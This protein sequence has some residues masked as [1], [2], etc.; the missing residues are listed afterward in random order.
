MYRRLHL[1]QPSMIIEKPKE[2]LPPMH[3][4]CSPCSSLRVLLVAEPGGWYQ[5]AAPGT[6][7]MPTIVFVGLA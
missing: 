2:Q 1:L 7:I 6:F 3:R 4:P 5:K